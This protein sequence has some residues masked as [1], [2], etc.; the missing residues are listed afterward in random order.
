MKSF[1]MITA[2]MTGLTVM[3]MADWT[4]NGGFSGHTET[5]VI[6]HMI[7]VGATSALWFVTAWLTGKEVRR[8]R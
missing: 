5:E 8:K 1:N 6:T 7:I 2:F 4:T 3:I